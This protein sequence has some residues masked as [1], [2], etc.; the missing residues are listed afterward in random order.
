MSTTGGRFTTWLSPTERLAL[1]TKASEEDSTSNYI[2]RKALRQYVGK[3]ALKA[4]AQQVMDVTGNT[5]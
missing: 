2:M 3:E 4:A 5:E 1:D